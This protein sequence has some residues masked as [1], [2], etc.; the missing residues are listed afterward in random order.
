METWEH[1]AHKANKR[2]F[3]LLYAAM[4]CFE[5]AEVAKAESEAEKRAKAGKEK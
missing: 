1:R 5:L 3:R 4:K 2:G